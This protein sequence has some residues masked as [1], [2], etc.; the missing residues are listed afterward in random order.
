MPA[1]SS[2]EEAEKCTS[3][4]RPSVDSLPPVQITK[5]S[6]NKMTPPHILL[7]GATPS[8]AALLLASGEYSHTQ[9]NPCCNVTA[10]EFAAG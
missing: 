6:N 10:E 3:K 1:R 7:L 2:E 4:I 8:R 5:A 9:C